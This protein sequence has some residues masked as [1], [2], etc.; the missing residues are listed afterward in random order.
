MTSFSATMFTCVSFFKI[1]TSRT[2]V[3]GNLNMRTLHPRQQ[4]GYPFN[5][6]TV[7][8]YLCWKRYAARDAKGESEVR[9][10]ERERERE[11]ERAKFELEL[12]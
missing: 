11:R 1:F 3:S 8:V 6:P 9:Q 2:A 4:S 12:I 5:A 7:E 10:R